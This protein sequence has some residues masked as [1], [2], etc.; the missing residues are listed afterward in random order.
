MRPSA[1]QLGIETEPGGKG[2]NQ[3][4]AASRLDVDQALDM[5]HGFGAKNVIITMGGEGS[6]VSQSGKRFYVEALKGEVVSTTGAGDCY[7]A[8]LAV[9][10]LETHRIPEAAEYASVAAGLQV[11]KPGVIANMPYRDEADAA[12]RKMQGTMVIKK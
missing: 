6:V 4:I 9:K 8:A 12:F 1:R 7:N 3:A 10:Y 2:Y 5:L 11:M